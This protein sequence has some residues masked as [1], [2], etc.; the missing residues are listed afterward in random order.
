MAVGK[1][2]TTRGEIPG[3]LL[4]LAAGVAWL[5]WALIANA[6]LLAAS[7]AGA[8][9]PPA[10][11]VSLGVCLAA[12]KLSEHAGAPACVRQPPPGARTLGKPR[13]L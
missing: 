9:L 4:L 6:Q 5:A 1:P 8:P 2:R 12:G 10:L 11:V 7:S 13:C 3:Q